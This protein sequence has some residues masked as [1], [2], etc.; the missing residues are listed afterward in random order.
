MIVGGPHPHGPNAPLDDDVFE[1]GVFEPAFEEG[2]RAGFQAGFAGGAEEDGVEV[3]GGEVGGQGVVW[4]TPFLM[5]R[6][7]V[8][9]PNGLK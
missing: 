3:F 2:A 8:L 7:D 5:K 9:G 4:R 1:T 6:L